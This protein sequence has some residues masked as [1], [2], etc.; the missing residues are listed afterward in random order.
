MN[1]L[2]IIIPYFGEFKPSISLFL[3][4]C[5]RNKDI[6]W[7][8]FT[9]CH[10]PKG[11]TINSNIKWIPATLKDVRLLAEEKLG[12]CVELDRAYK[13]CDLKPFYGLIFEN[14]LH[15]YEYWGYG[16]V[17]VVYGRLFHFLNQIGYTHYDKINWMGHLCFIR[18]NVRCNKA[19]LL[20]AKG[21]IE[22]EMVLRNSENV[23]FDERDFNIKCIKS[24]MKIYMGK[25]AA[26]IDIF[27]WRMRCVDIWTLHLLLNTYAI[28][29][30]P[31]NYQKQIFAIVNGIAYR[32]YLKKGKVFF[33]EF[34]YIHFRKEYTIEFNEL[35]IDSYIITREGFKLIENGKEL[36]SDYDKVLSI[37]NKYNNQENWLQEKRCFL[38]HYY[39]KITGKRGW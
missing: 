22:A 33:E 28:K 5:N 18:N 6:D 34:A 27:Y 39:R 37:I 1:R 2:A 26:D 9:D 23:G 19:G 4:S 12:M 35:G 11:V 31:R 29:Y 8:V 7:F 14:Y 13:L 24:G 16:D 30:A 3:A 15:D 38:Y 20:H 10:V 17:D 25:W 21:T 36:F 32:I